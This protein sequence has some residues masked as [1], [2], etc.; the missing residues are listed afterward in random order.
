MQ[1]LK[2]V[3]KRLFCLPPL[4]TV[5]ISLPSFVFVFVMLSVG[6]DTP[7]AYLSYLLSAYALVITATGA[8]GVGAAMR[9]GFGNLPLIQKL[10]ATALGRRLLDDAFFRSEVALHGGLVTGLLYVALNFFSGFR[11]RSAWFLSLAVY[12]TLLSLM[13]G[14]LVYYIHRRPVGQNI[15][16]EFRRYRACGVLLLLMN[17]ALVGILLYMVTQQRGF[18]YPGLLIYAMALYTFYITIAAVVQVVRF[19]R[20]GS[21]LLSAAKVV[22]LTAALVSMLSLETAMLS[23][24]GGSA[25]FRRTML[26]ASGGGVCAIVLTMAIYM[27]V[28]STRQLR[29]AAAQS[30]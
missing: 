4:P 20:R 29:A 6:Q 15:P 27:I 30:K 11:Y 12:Y 17:Q 26:A 7:L 8:A 21:P 24:F 22:N 19:R 1:R 14:V 25:A 18:S 10:R 9:A 13:R 23:Q 16:A 2:Q 28:H 3:L 5:L